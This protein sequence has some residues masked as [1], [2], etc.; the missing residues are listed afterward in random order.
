MATKEDK[1]EP[2]FPD[3]IPVVE[4]KPGTVHPD[5]E[6][7]KGKY[8]RKSD[9]EVYALAVVEDDPNGR[10]HKAINNVH[11][12]EGTEHQFAMEFTEVGKEGAAKKIPSL[13]PTFEEREK[14][15]KEEESKAKK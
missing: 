10:T 13:N 5:L 9:G 14:A 2:R 6:D 11:Y 15:R 8:T 12:W 4:P 1:P 7:Y 3:N